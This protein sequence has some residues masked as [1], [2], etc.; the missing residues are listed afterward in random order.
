MI[1]YADVI[2]PLATPPMTF[3]VEESL[4]PQL[5]VGMRVM[6]PFGARKFYA[7]IVYRLHD[8]KPPYEHIK[9]V[10][11]IIDA[12]EAVLPEQLRLWEW[13]ANYYMC[14]LG[15]VMRTA[16]P[17]KLKLDGYSEQETL[18]GGYHPPKVTHVGLVDEIDSEEKLHAVLDRLGR[19]K[20]QYRAV[21]EYLAR[22]GFALEETGESLSAA[23]RNKV[24][25]N[26]CSDTTPSCESENSSAV[27]E[28]Q[29]HEAPKNSLEAGQNV[30][31]AWPLVPRESLG[32][33][34]AIIR[35]LVD[36]GLFRQVELE[37]TPQ[38]GSEF[39][40]G[41][42]GIA[43]LPQLTAAQQQ[44][45][46]RLTAGFADREVMLLHGVTGSGK[47][48]I[49]IHL[50]AE[51][52]AAGGN[53][54]YMLPEIALTTQLIERMCS[55]FGDRVIVYHSR[56]TDNRRAEVYRELLVSQGGRLVI[57][58]RS[59][60]LLPL[61]MLSLVVIDEEHENSFKQSDSAP[62]YQARDTAIVLAS[63]YGA[64][65][66]LGSATPSME[67]YFNAISGKY[68]LV[69]LTERYGGASLPQ[70]LI[71]DTLRAARRGEKRSHFNK[72]LLDRID[73][74]LVKGQQVM[75]FQNRRGFS[76]FVECGQC[77]WTAT[78]PDCNVT[79][80]YHKSDRSLRCHYCGYHTALPACCPSCGTDD[81]QPRGFG[82][83]KVEE[84]L[85]E[86]FPHAVIDRLDADTSR[87]PQSY[88]R[89]ISAFERG[90]TDILIGTQM[91]TKGFDFDRVALVGIL[92]ADNLLNYP[93][94][95]A[96]E[97][98]FQ[99]MMQVGGRAGR[100]SE[101]GV[102]VIQTSQPGHPVLEQVRRGD[103]EAMARMQL[104]ER[105]SFLY[106]P[107]C[108][109][110]AL[111]L[112]HRDKALL[113]EVAA[114]LGDELR[115]IFGRRVLGPE[116]PPVDRIRGQY[117]TRFL[118]KIERKSSVAEAKSLLTGVL[119]S[120]HRDKRYRAVEL[121]PDVDPQ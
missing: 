57:G 99:L 79:L 117:L 15:M 10:V 14:P 84:A 75:L 30:F 3:A 44:A 108:R 35:A 59:S 116:A 97:R 60:V 28:H 37:V 82:T 48:E 49:Y 63:F 73:E 103:Y 21:T 85:A 25:Q 120:L 70:V 67:S 111:T 8:Q 33:S 27:S 26:V 31:R 118:L 32:V 55:Y 62:R 29:Q 93:D 9:S 43:P 81:L 121:I 61:P 100:R 115:R 47:T 113:G 36:R 112:R 20:M 34:S 23:T 41:G 64:K 74:I 45:Y 38:E 16:L 107:Y 76:P 77:G 110:I 119:E 5:R 54:L 22:V 18:R 101:Q 66:V 104:A 106:P 87:S 52:L 69:T 102:V 46:E 51:R 114:R 42:E 2:L 12:Q 40:A 105:R 7:G 56:L 86:I 11:R 94:F 4:C 80:T 68:G 88:R 53:V 50:M 58:V 98:A 90:D 109:L 1:R 83:E 72:L 91:I 96:G 6:V 13:I 24:Q 39:A 19:A 17:A 71:S 65:C 92:N 78:C 95:R 89:I